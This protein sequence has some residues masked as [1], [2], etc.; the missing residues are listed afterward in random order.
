LIPTIN[1]PEEAVKLLDKLNKQGQA[2][3][4]LDVAQYAIRRWPDHLPLVLD[5]ANI[6]KGVG[7]NLIAID[8][9]SHAIE[10]G[11]D[12]AVRDKQ[13]LIDIAAP[14]WHFRMMND[15]VRNN[16]YDKAI[17]HY[18]SSDTLVLDI[19]CGAGLLSMMA[20]RAGAEHVYACEMHELMHNKATQ[21]F[22]Q[23]GFA[24]HI[25]AYHLNSTQL[26][27][28]KHLPR[29]ADI[30]VAEVFDSGLLG[31]DALTT[32]AHA[33]EHL[34]A[35]GGRILPAQASIQA[36]LVDSELMHKESFSYK[37]AGFDVSEL[38]SLSPSYHQ[39]R[40][41]THEH[42]FLSDVKTID[43]FNFEM[44]EI[45]NRCQEIKFVCEHS[46][47]CHGVVFWFT[48]DFCEGTTLSTGP[49]NTWNCW[50]QAMC[51]FEKPRNVEVGDVLA[52][53]AHITVNRVSFELLD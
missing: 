51:S 42:R 4:R 49:E 38:N 34:L 15:E 12:Q 46:G 37:C 44:Q 24:D 41:N 19:G 8:L 10:L 3:A 16:A 14:Y 13:A 20:A 18:V 26:E 5:V 21:I 27:V 33:R 29:K 48:L 1:A 50:K 45:D 25:T 40:V 30:I 39:I 2:S 7:K 52:M 28:G 22:K 36:Q 6:A 53:K 32:F 43:D 23:N 47:V 35:P 11:S 17:K 31:E 9:L